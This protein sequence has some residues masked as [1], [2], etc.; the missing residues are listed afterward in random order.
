MGEQNSQYKLSELFFRVLEN[1]ISDDL[2]V[3][4]RE[5][6]SENPEIRQYYVE[7]MNV[8]AILHQ[9]S[10]VSSATIPPEYSDLSE[11]QRIL[12]EVIDKD[13][14]NRAAHE[15]ENKLQ[16][17]ETRRENIRKSAEETFA[18]FLEDERRRQEK[19]AYKRYK[20][21]QR[22][23]I[24]GISSLAASLVLVFI[25]WF[26]NR[27][28]S[29]PISS[30]PV[31]LGLAVITD[32]VNVKWA[33]M[34]EGPQVGDYLQ[35]QTLELTDGFVQM[36]LGKGIDVIVQGPAK[37]DLESDKQIY[38]ES[39]T[40]SAEVP[41]GITG[42]LVKTPSATVVDYGTEFGVK[43]YET[44]DMETHVFQGAVE[45]RSGPDEL[46]YRDARRL[47]IG[48]AG[49]V[50]NEGKIAQGEFQAQ[51]D[52]FAQTMQEVHS[53]AFLL[54]RNLI[55]NGDFE[56]GPRGRYDAERGQP[57]DVAIWGWEDPCSATIMAYPDISTPH[58]NQ[59]PIINRDPLPTSRGNNFFVGND[60]GTISQTV[61]LTLLTNLID[62]KE[63]NYEL[64][65]WLGGFNEHKDS[66]ELKLFFINEN[67]A[68]RGT[69]H[70]SSHTPL[71]R[72]N[73]T[74]F[75]ELRTSGI[76]PQGTRIIKI[77][78]RSRK[79]AGVMSDSYADNLSL[80][81]RQTNQ[82]AFITKF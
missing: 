38:L 2:L 63:I 68:E 26:F 74:G 70:I 48:S 24:L 12:A 13:L 55:E 73:Q 19:L 62:R 67:G 35:S 33:D 37:F 76:V 50:D 79:Y 41:G 1:D 81:L 49:R 44:G 32:Q 58:A 20:A 16:E 72:K 66:V 46:V 15:M 59:F 6:L 21:R 56:R 39:G 23:L 3:L 5:K 65:G 75:W 11:D 17:A 47:K 64:S 18:K 8:C 4:L 53:G 7:F 51:R 14:Q 31:P 61:N 9:H 42:F 69:A 77:E 22:R 80:I 25:V 60:N 71:Q 40:L 82:E 54:K 78:L 28:A 57:T 27:P 43:V 52:K 45:L 36:T 10:D 29:E 30:A 34:A